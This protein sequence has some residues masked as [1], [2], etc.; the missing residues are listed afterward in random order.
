MNWKKAKYLGLSRIGW[1]ASKFGAVNV[2]RV[3]LG[4][5]H[6]VA[7]IF[8]SIMIVPVILV[9]LFTDTTIIEYH[10]DNFCWW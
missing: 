7:W 1:I 10:E 9:C 3:R 2:N 6:P 8:Y 5:L 4:V